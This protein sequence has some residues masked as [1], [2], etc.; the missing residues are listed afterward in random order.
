MVLSRIININGTRI[1]FR[2]QDI[3]LTTLQNEQINGLW[4]R[5]VLEGFKFF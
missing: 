5:N 3:T 1:H 4:H 2:A